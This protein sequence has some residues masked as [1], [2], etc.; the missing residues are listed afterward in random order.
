MFFSMG[1]EQ[2]NILC[3]C[4]EFAFIDA[5]FSSGFSRHILVFKK[6]SRVS[7]STQPVS[8]SHLAE[9]NFF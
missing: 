9:F 1:M 8:R 7:H 6:F 3:L 2:E 5:V 4:S